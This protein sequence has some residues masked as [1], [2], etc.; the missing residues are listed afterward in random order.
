MARRRRKI[1]RRKRNLRWT[2]FNAFSF[3]QTGSL[4][5]SVIYSPA[6]SGDTILRPRTKV[7]RIRG[8]IVIIANA[9]TAEGLMGGY[10][11]TFGTDETETVLTGAPWA[12]L[13]QDP[14]IAR[15][16]IM[17]QFSH[18]HQAFDEATVQPVRI[19]IDVK[20]SRMLSPARS[21]FLVTQ[22]TGTNTALVSG[23]CRALL[24]MG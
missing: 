23:H 22:G 12:V 8:E 7:I 19:P 15:K 6:S 2:G 21:L 4:V 9:G 1:F 17:W 11:T 10:I 20:V 13:T 16:G 3:T 5:E 24:D 14:D 18:T